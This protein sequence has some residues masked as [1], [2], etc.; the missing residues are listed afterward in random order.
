MITILDSI[1]ANSGKIDEIDV[2]RRLSYWTFNGFTELGDESGAGLGV[3]VISVVGNPQFTKSPHA[4]AQKVYEKSKGKAAA[5]GGLCA[6]LFLAFHTFRT[7]K[8]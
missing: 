6:L 5:N 7:W 4:V 1:I 2:A 3:T 8:K